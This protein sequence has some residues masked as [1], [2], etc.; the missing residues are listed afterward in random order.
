MTHKHSR[1]VFII[2]IGLIVLYLLFRH[3]AFLWMAVA[4]G[5][6]GILVPRAAYAIDWIWTR[7]TEMLGWLG[8]RVIL[9]VVYLV[10]LVPVSM[11][12]RL[13][14]K[15]HL[16]LRKPA[17]TNWKERRQTYTAGDMVDPF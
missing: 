7:L 3:N 12:S 8:S 9:G 5:V 1:T 2:Q 16:V 6:A 4:L 14:R 10:V 17:K 13:F 15:D 11:V